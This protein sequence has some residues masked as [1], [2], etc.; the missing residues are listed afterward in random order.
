VRTPNTPAAADPARKSRHPSSPVNRMGG[1]E[2][3]QS[4]LKTPRVVAAIPPPEAAS[5]PHKSWNIS[6]PRIAGFGWL[7]VDKTAPE[8]G[9]LRVRP[10]M[11]GRRVSRTAGDGRR[12]VN[13]GLEMNV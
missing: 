9:K 10:S 3:L 4:G 1:V 7:E 13:A 5:P 8:M 11:M 12:A 2:S 6:D